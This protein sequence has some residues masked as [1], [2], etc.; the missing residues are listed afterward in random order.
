MDFYHLFEDEDKRVVPLSPKVVRRLKM[1]TPPSTPSRLK[2][3][4]LVEESDSSSHE[5][6]DSATVCFIG[7]FIL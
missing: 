7:I 3:P 2:V 1:R 6:R 4:E 5:G